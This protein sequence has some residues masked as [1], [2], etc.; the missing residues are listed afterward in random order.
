MIERLKSKFLELHPNEKLPSVLM[1][2]MDDIQRKYFE[3]ERLEYEEN[4]RNESEDWDFSEDEI[5]AINFINARRLS[6]P[7]SYGQVVD[8]FVAGMEEE[9][10]RAPQPQNKLEDY[11]DAELAQELSNRLKS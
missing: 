3:E 11:T 8:Y 5:T 4:L 6:G 10:E 9:R 1:P 2:L 7:I